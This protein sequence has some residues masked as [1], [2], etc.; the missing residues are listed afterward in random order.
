MEWWL[1]G[2]APLLNSL[3]PS[4]DYGKLIAA[5]ELQS[6]RRPCLGTGLAV[7]VAVAADVEVV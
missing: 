1:P 3:K 7:V 5:V 4:F 2:E 6:F